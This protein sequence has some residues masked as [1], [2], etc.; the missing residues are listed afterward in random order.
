MPDKVFEFLRSMICICLLIIA[1]LSIMAYSEETDDY[2][3]YQLGIK[4]KNEN[5][6]DQA[7]EEFRKVLTAYP[8]NYNAYMQLAEISKSQN[9]PELEI[10]ALNKALTY[11]P[12]WGKAAIMLSEA[13]EFGKQYQKSIM[14]LQKYQQTCDPEERNGVQKKIDMLIK[15]VQ[16]SVAGKPESDSLNSFA[17][18]AK[19]SMTGKSAFDSLAGH[20]NSKQTRKSGPKDM[21]VSA[22]Q[23]LK[24]AIQLN[25]QGKTAEALQYVKKAVLLKPDWAEAYYYAGMM[26]Y[27]QGQLDLAKTNFS[28]SSSFP[29]SHYFMGKIYGTEK[30]YKGAVKELST[31][32]TVA[33]DSVQ[34]QDALKLLV[35]YKRKINDTTA[36]LPAAVQS[37]PATSPVEAEPVQPM[38]VAPESA[39]VVV[40]MRA[41]SFMTMQ[42]VDTLT[43][44]G[45]AMLAG[46]NEYKAGHFEEAVKTFKKV[47]STYASNNVTIPCIYDIGIC[48]L[49]LRLFPNADNQFDNLCNRYPD[50][51]LAAR[52]LFLKAFSAFERGDMTI[53]EKLFR[54]FIRKYRN[55]AW[56]GQAYEKLGDVYSDMKQYNKAMDAYRQAANI[57]KNTADQISSYFKL[58]NICFE[59]GNPEQ[60]I[61]SFK[62]VIET[63]ESAKISSHVADSYYKI[64]DFLYQRKDYKTALDNYTKAA[65]KYPDC[66]ETPWGL[67]QMGNIYINTADYHK[68]IE[69]YKELIAKHPDDYWA[70]QARWKMDDAVWENEYKNVLQ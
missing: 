25:E 31:F 12:G 15:K 24:K 51:L 5:K 33:R 56:T 30:Y 60:A 13:Y 6:F 38:P 16:G 42:V 69:S 43:N 57:A 65:R 20:K 17:I 23:A 62:K 7:V 46:V 26:R 44:Q 29:S 53:S 58:G 35:D 48:Y 67:F 68:A 59:A 27:K 9:Q 3:H 39:Q 18:S 2:I 66:P 4:F 70:K 54:D 61:V 11:N 10:Y 32:V 22:E 1:G 64:A 8:D 19:D 47:M 40:E 50:H 55:N 49:K 41:D 37:A 36:V 52:S 21:P 63:G 34:K 45:Q 28:K 14:E